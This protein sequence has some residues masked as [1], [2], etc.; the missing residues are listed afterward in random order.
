ML[1]THVR[2]HIQTHDTQADKRGAAKGRSHV[3]YEEED[4]CSAHGAA[5]GRSP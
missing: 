3:S 5:K 1:G 2:H 4:T